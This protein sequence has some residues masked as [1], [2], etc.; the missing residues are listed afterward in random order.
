VK[1]ETTCYVKDGKLFFRNRNQIEKDC[2]NSGITEF[3]VTIEKR[4]KKRSYEQ[5]KYYWGVV[6]FLIRQRFVELGN[7]VSKEE[8]HDYLKHEFN[9]KE[10]VNEKTSEV[11][12]IPM[13]TANLTTSEFMDYIAKIQI[14]AADIL[15]VV[16]PDPNTQTSLML[17]TE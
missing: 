15:G 17:K 2:V 13:S 1:I 16:I 11:I 12:R 5:S 3:V 14:F 4:K 8:T 6:V 9:Y 7:D 10:F